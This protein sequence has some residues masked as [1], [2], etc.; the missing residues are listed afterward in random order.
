MNRTALVRC[1]ALAALLL[2]SACQSTSQSAGSNELAAQVGV[3][4]PPPPGLSRPRLGIP[5][6]AVGSSASGDMNVLAADQLSTLMVRTDRFD[7][8]ERSQLEA[9]L[10]EQ[11]LEGIVEASEMARPAEIRGVDYLL[12]GRIT[13]LRTRATRTGSNSGFGKILSLG[14]GYLGNGGGVG[15]GVD[16]DSEKVEMKVE[17][18]V[19][20]RLVDPSTGSVFEATSSEYTRTD[21]ASAFGVQVL[22]VGADADADI[23]MSEDDHGLVMRLALDDAIRDMLPSLDR[24]L[25][26]L[27][28]ARAGASS[29]SGAAASGATAGG[30]AAGFCGQCGASRVAD[31]A[32]C[33]G[34]GARIGG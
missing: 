1:G 26:A 30:S 24:K 10:A 12:L 6:V 8:I 27:G 4:S 29:A 17:C 14:K 5:P 32:F 20:L 9:L 7:V 2:A 25:A 11:D 34:C 21:K 19:D 31:A 15:G 28:R 3:Y 22:G 33:T 13:N 16:I 18:G 23:Q